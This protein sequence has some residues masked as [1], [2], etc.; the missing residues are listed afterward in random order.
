MNERS[1]GAMIR[2]TDSPMAT[3]TSDMTIVC[4]ADAPLRI[5]A[6]ASTGGSSYTTGF[7]VRDSLFPTGGPAFVNKAAVHVIVYDVT[8]DTA[9]ASANF[10]VSSMI[11]GSNKGNFNVVAGHIYTLIITVTFEAK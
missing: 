9:V 5:S 4:S 8:A 10:E 2:S 6:S 11:N 1:G 3:V 7:F